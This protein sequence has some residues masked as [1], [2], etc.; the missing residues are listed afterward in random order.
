MVRGRVGVG[1]S[2]SEPTDLKHCQNTYRHLP[3]GRSRSGPYS[4]SV[5]QAFNL[6]GSEIKI[7][8]GNRTEREQVFF[9]LNF[10]QQC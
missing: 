6:T 5:Q 2:L 4:H 9:F 8:C 7:S 10:E 1:H 3:T